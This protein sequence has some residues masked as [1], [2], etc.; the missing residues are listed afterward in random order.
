M[1]ERINS[2][3]LSYRYW[4]DEPGND[5]MWFWS[6]NHVLCF[7]TSQL[8][9]GDYLPDAIF[10]ASGRTGREQAVLAADRL[11]R[12][13]DSVEA[14]GLAEWNSAA[15]YPV[16]FIGLLAIEHWAEP[17]LAARARHQLDLIFEMIALHTLGGV[18]SGSQGGA[19]DR[20]CAPG[21]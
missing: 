18:P 11:R 6:E 12:W 21:R 8:L 3:I 20:S 19:Y 7:H 17:E 1:L 5:V 14:H 9:A 15:Y 4:V 10:S 2:S 13:F 16:D